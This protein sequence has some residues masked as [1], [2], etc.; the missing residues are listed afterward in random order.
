MSIEYGQGYSVPNGISSQDRR[1]D[2][3]P[4]A[5]VFSG[6]I[7]PCALSIL[8]RKESVF[9]SLCGLCVSAVDFFCF[10]VKKH[11]TNP[12]GEGKHAVHVEICVKKG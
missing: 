8:E 9:F 6:L 4:M 2:S 11:L 3:D 12:T 7:P 10:G 1:S 5:I